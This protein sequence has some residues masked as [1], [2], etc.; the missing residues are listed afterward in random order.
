MK[1][2]SKD[3]THTVAMLPAMGVVSA[4]VKDFSNDPFVTKKVAAALKRIERVGFPTA[5]VTT[6]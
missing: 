6:K 4:D 2:N 5:F 1:S 3:K